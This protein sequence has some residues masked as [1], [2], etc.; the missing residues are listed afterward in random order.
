MV[1]I[2][3]CPNETWSTQSVEQVEETVSRFEEFL[4]GLRTK[5][6]RVNYSWGITCVLGDPD[7][8]L[9]LA[10]SDRRKAEEKLI[11]FINR[12]YIVSCN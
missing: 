11:E 10:K 12:A 4:E 6:T 1:Q 5:A 3:V 7:A 8:F 2:R 9:L